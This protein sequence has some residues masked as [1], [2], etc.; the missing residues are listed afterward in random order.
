MVIDITELYP[1]DRELDIKVGSDTLLGSEGEEIWLPEFEFGA[2][3]SATV[4]GTVMRFPGVRSFMGRRPMTTANRIIGPAPLSV[5]FDAIGP[6]SGVVQPMVLPP[7][8]V[9]P[10]WTGE[11]FLWNFDD[12]ATYVGGQENWSISGKAKSRAYGYLAQHTYETPGTY[13]VKLL[14]IDFFGNKFHY[15]QTITAED[16]EVVFAGQTTYYDDVA[17]DDTIGLGTELLPWK[18]FSKAMTTLLASNGPRRVKVKAG[19]NYTQAAAVTGA[20]GLT[21]PF[22]IEAYGT[23]TKPKIVFTNNGPGFENTNIPDLRVVGVDITNTNASAP[24][25]DRA[26][27]FVYGPYLLAKDLKVD[28]NYDVGVLSISSNADECTLHNV[29]ITSVWANNHYAIYYSAGSQTNQLPQ[30]LAIMGCRLGPNN[31]NSTLRTYASRSIWEHSDIGPGD[32]S[33]T[34]WLGQ[35]GSSLSE[36]GVVSDNKIHDSVGWLMEI[37]PENHEQPQVVEGLIVENNSFYTE[38]GGDVQRAVLIWA[39]Y[40]CFRNN[41]IYFGNAGGTHSTSGC[42]MTVGRRSPT[43]VNAPIPI[44]TRIYHNSVYTRNPHPGGEPFTLVNIAEHIG[45]CQVWNNI[46][47]SSAAV[48]TDVAEGSGTANIDSRT[49]LVGVLNADLMFVNPGANDLHL[50]ANAPAIGGSTLC[51]GRYDFDGNR[52]PDTG[53]R[54]DRGCYERLA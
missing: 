31:T 42:A 1:E 14:K 19:S 51:T 37:G 44:G 8:W 2:G 12:A 34:R 38:L 6:Q 33:T 30:H 48:A 7:G 27:F 11:D 43:H 9:K 16:P 29:E 35:P 21:G 52:R 23:G 53:I 54:R 41:K 32:Q 22:Q 50:I 40:V 49:N 24:N 15:Y 13:V 46:C 36:Y 18:T 10:D 47:C 4:G 5:F 25:G 39:S 3:F 17:G 26:A 45:P 28:G 20:G